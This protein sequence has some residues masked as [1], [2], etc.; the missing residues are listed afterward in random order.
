MIRTALTLAMLLAWPAVG[1][2]QSLAITGPDRCG[3]LEGRSYRLTWS[4][5]GLKSVSLVA[6]GERT[7]LGTRSR[8]SFRKVIAAGAPASRGGVTWQVPWIDSTR[9]TIKVKG[10]NPQGQLVA[11][12]TR[13]YHFRPAILARRTKDGIYLD[14]HQRRGQRLYVQRGG[15]ITHAFLSSSSENYSWQPRNRHTAAPHDHAGVFRVVQKSKMHWSQLF[16]VPMPFALRYHGGHFI[17]ATSRN[18][19]RKLGRPASHGCNRL[20]RHDARILYGM[21]PIGTRVEVIGPGG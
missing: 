4:I 11:T 6:Y 7:P 9:L 14:L 20:T 15:R 16:D 12:D 18:L 13:G 21:T 19:Y 10:Y 3:V 8:G 17:H 2:A 5:S 1:H